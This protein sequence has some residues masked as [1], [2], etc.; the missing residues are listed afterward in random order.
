M[1]QLKK[2]LMSLIKLYALLSGGL[3]LAWIGGVS[4]KLFV[5]FCIA[6]IVIAALGTFLKA[7]ALKDI[8]SEPKTPGL[9]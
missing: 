8:G 4:G 2:N 1:K 5:T 3:L 7:I 9:V 6:A